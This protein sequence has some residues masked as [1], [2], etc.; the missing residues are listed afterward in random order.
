M[1]GP[2]QPL[3]RGAGTFILEFIS[4]FLPHPLGGCMEPKMPQTGSL[5]SRTSVLPLAVQLILD[6]HLGRPPPQF[7]HL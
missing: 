2:H 3:L 6:K 5:K 4:F 7:T 1:A